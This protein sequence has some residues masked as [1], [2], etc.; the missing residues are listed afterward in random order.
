MKELGLRPA[1][2]NVGLGFNVGIGGKQ[3]M[4]V[5][6]QKLSLARALIKRPDLLIIN[7]GFAA[8]DANQQ[9]QMVERVLNGVKNSRG[10]AQSGVFWVLTNPNLAAKFEQVLVFRNGGL[11]EQDTPM[12]LERKESHY[13]E[14]VA[15]GK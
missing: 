9:T 11:V 10:E 3:L 14:L 13:S 5:Q 2:I 1:V 12:A 8:L 6:R 15:H 4:A 7:K